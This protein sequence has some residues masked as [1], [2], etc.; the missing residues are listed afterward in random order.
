M[1]PRYDVFLSHATADK[2]AVEFLARKLRE[3]GIEPFLDKWHLIPGE[4]WEEALEEALD[5]SQTCAVFLG[6]TGIG[7]WQNEEMRSELAARVRDKTHRVIPVLLPGSFEPRKEE[8]PRFLA[9]LNWVDF[10]AGLDDEEAFRRLVSGIRGI[11]PGPGGSDSRGEAVKSP[12]LL[13]KRTTQSVEALTHK[14]NSYATINPTGAERTEKS[15]VI[16]VLLTIVVL[17]IIVM[18]ASLFSLWRAD[19]PKKPETPYREVPA[20]KP[21]PPGRITDK[22]PLPQEDSL[23]ELDKKLIN[24]VRFY[25]SDKDIESLLSRGARFTPA[26]LVQAAYTKNTKLIEKIID[27]DVPINSRGGEPISPHIGFYAAVDNPLSVAVSGLDKSTTSFL[28]SKKADPN[29][30]NRKMESQFAV[31]LSGRIMLGNAASGFIA[32]DDKK[33]FEII[34]EL[35]AAGGDINSQDGEGRTV[36]MIAA[37]KGEHEWVKFLLKKGAKKEVADKRG[38]LAR[39]YAERRADYDLARFLDPGV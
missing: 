23:S 11:A 22:D 27:A 34:E 10:R 30:L 26:C 12:P 35:V 24:E 29:F 33:L 5:E 3:Q 8:L 19:K 6:P 2:P 25:S 38:Y 7:G 28:L 20:P 32:N 4:P 17:G 15:R 31:A 39:D 1:S 37:E 36:L 21:R 16:M 18:M 13:L 14:D 9:R